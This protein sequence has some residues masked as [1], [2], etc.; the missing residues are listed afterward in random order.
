MVCPCLVQGFVYGI[1]LHPLV[2][3]LIHEAETGDTI[4]DRYEQ[5]GV[6]S[7]EVIIILEQRE[8]MVPI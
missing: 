4:K 1:L 6:I 5:N 8:Q 7:Y 3:I 2:K